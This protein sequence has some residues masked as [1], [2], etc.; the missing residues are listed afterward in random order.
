MGRERNRCLYGYGFQDWRDT[1]STLE[2]E[3]KNPDVKHIE[4]ETR[5]LFEQVR[6]I[7]E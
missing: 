2:P 1:Y 7:T 5:Q 4:P 6:D 3:V